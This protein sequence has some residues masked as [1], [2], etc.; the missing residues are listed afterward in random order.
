MSLNLATEWLARFNAAMAAKSAPVA[1][2]PPPS[3][4]PGNDTAPSG[5][6]PVATPPPKNDMDKD[7]SPDSDDKGTQPDIDDAEWYVGHVLDYERDPQTGLAK[8][9]LTF[10]RMVKDVK[11]PNQKRSKLATKP[12]DPSPEQP[13]T[14]VP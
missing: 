8:W 13:P 12:G 11:L 14:A 6:N 2:K 7:E 1:P 9:P 10:K 4:F 3:A 5:N